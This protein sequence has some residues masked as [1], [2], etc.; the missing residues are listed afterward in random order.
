MLDRIAEIDEWTGG[1]LHVPSYPAG[2]ENPGCEILM[3]IVGTGYERVFPE[4]PGTY[5]CEGNRGQ[6]TGP[7]VDGRR[8]RRES[9]L[10]DVHRLRRRTWVTSSTSR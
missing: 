9:D 1:G 3:Q 8:S 5:E 4:G 2:N 6:V 10:D 7:V